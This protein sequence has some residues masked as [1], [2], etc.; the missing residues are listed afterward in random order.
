MKMKFIFLILTISLS[1]CVMGI[2]ESK[3]RVLIVDGYGNHDWRSLFDGH[4]LDG[5]SVH[6][7]P[8]DKDKRFWFAK[9]G[10]IECNSIGHGDHDYIW[11]IYDEEFDD[12]QLVLQFQIFKSSKGNSG[13]Q[14][15]SRFDD[16]ESARKGGW[17]NGPQ[18]DIHPPNPLRAGLIYDETDGVNR[19]IYPSLPDYNMVAEK[20]PKPAHQTKLVYA[21]DD[22]DAWNSMEIICEGMHIET[23]VNGIRIT[24]FDAEGILNDALHLEKNVGTTGKIAL[25]LHAHDELLIRFKEIMI[26]EIE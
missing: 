18:A 21:E 17:L 5:W 7:L 8:A 10:Y 24:D 19:W 14:F 12:F 23:F 20:A 6:C 16:S 25:H 9:D 2:G 4:S 13:V 22:P 3:T 11:L 26:R 1:V 15:R